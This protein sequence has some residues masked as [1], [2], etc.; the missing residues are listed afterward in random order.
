MQFPTVVQFD[1]EREAIEVSEP[2]DTVSAMR[3][4]AKSSEEWLHLR[5]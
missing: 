2:G 1:Q 4:L 5:E 3:Y